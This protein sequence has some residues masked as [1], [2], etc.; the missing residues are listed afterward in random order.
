MGKSLV[1]RPIL[2]A[3]PTPTTSCPQALF[4]GH[5]AFHALSPHSYPQPVLR[6]RSALSTVGLTRKGWLAPDVDVGG[7]CCS[8]QRR[9]PWETTAAARSP[10]SKAPP[11]REPDALQE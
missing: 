5:T 8:E 7:R 10:M 2:L 3:T 9:T 4:T 6:L 1:K 11:P